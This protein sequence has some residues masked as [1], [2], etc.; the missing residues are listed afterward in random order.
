[1]AFNTGGQPPQAPAFHAD[2]CQGPPAT[3]GKPQL[4]QLPL[5]PPPPPRKGFGAPGDGRQ[6]QLQLQKRSQIRRC[7]ESWGYPQLSSLSMGF[8]VR[9]HLFWVPPLFMETSRSGSNL[10]IPAMCCAPSYKLVY[11]PIIDISSIIPTSW[12]YV[13]QVV[14]ILNWGTTFFWISH[15]HDL[16]ARQPELPSNSDR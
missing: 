6:G 10:P 8:S 3:I 11:K 16:G 4:P 1:M 14:A 15:R 7:P 5:A 13:H 2:R 9:N 12:S